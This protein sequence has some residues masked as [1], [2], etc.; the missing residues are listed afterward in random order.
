MSNNPY[1]TPSSPPGMAKRATQTDTEQFDLEQVVSGQKLV[2]YAIMGYLCSIL[3]L[4]SSNAFLGGTP[5]APVVTPLFGVVLAIGGLG[6]LASAIGACVGVF[7]M[8]GVLYPGSTRYVYAAGVLTPAPLIG[9]LVM[10][11]ASSA[12]TKYLRARGIKVGFFGASR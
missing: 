10:F 3:V 6:L 1:A 11:V 12:A 9:L 2:I 8:G 7:R 4:V 5:K